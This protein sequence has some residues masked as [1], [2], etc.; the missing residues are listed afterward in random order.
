VFSILC[1]IVFL[2]HP[3]PETHKNITYHKFP[4]HYHPYFD[5]K[6]LVDKGNKNNIKSTVEHDKHDGIIGDY[7]TNEFW[8]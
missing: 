6:N 3:A 7:L 4:L 1:V 8:C 2:A 5:K